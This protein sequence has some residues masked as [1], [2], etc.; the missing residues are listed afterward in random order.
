MKRQKKLLVLCLAFA[1]LLGGYGAIKV[2]TAPTPVAD[3]Q[4]K[5]YSLG[6]SDSLT[7]MQWKYEEVAV[8]LSFSDNKWV[9]SDD[10]TCPLDQAA[11]KKL[12]ARAA[13]LYATKVITD[14][15]SASA[16]G[17]DS[18]EAVTL[19]FASGS[20]SVTMTLGNTD[21]Y[22]SSA[23]VMLNNDASKVYLVSS[24]SLTAFVVT[25]NDLVEKEA[26][27]AFTDV[28]NLQ[29]SGKTN[30]D[31]SFSDGGS[32]IC[33]TN[34]YEWF[35]RDGNKLLPL[36]PDAVEDLM[37]DLTTLTWGDCV[38][39]KADA[40]ALTS[41]GLDTPSLT[42]TALYN[43]STTA[44][45]VTIH[46]GGFNS[47]EN[48]YYARLDGSKM[49][50]LVSKTMYDTL[51]AVSYD[52]LRALDVLYVDWF[53]VSD[54][55]ITAAGASHTIKLVEVTGPDGTT[56]MMFDLD[57]ATVDTKL[58]SAFLTAMSSMQATETGKTAD[59]AVAFTVSLRQYSHTDRTVLTFAP[60]GDGYV[61]QVNGS[62]DLWITAAQYKTI[63]DAYNT[64]LAK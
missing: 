35:L 33:Y 17:F 58:T 26:L 40:D 47:D 12:A 25:L 44:G 13:G 4:Q 62:G 57:G 41:Y 39:Y 8:N 52:T 5:T 1:L 45:T 7:A 30:A 19:T 27:P 43:E 21:P 3:S 63:T 2:L 55:E 61:V 10:Q 36:D 38:N 48:A 20:G 53:N 64:L 46:F 18:D 60:G 56:S 11:V 23:Y 16:Y 59:S 29:L 22:G 24:D 9:S 14:P 28:L 15:E 50:Y 37:D 54:L 49:V 34:L 32:T 42:L 31:I 6:I 51:A